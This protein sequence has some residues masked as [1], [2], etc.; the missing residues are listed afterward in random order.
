MHHFD[1]C[2]YSDIFESLKNLKNHL[3][4][5][6]ETNGKISITDLKNPFDKHIYIKIYNMLAHLFHTTSIQIN[7]Y[8]N[9][10][11]YPSPTEVQKILRENHDIPVAG[12][13]GSSRMFNKIH[14]QYY[15]KN[16]RSEIENYVKNCNQC[17]T[18]KALRKINRASM[19]ITST[20]VAPF[21][22]LS[23]GPAWPTLHGVHHLEVP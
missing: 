23:L 5:L 4:S 17:Q 22:M 11:Y 20:S 19:Q 8:R 9:K 3:I 21:E 18:K 1:N 6:D 13:L 15:W 7:I 10:V 16:M 14:E 12:H 2:T